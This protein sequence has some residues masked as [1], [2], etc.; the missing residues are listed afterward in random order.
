MDRFSELIISQSQV[1]SISQ[2][3]LTP[4][5]IGFAWRSAIWRKPL[6]LIQVGLMQLIGASLIFSIGMIPID[7]V[8]H[9]SNLDRS[10]QERTAQLIWVD[11]VLTILLLSGANWWMFARTRRLQ[12]LVKLVE[13]IE[14][15]NQ[16][17]TS[18]STLAKVANLTA[19]DSSPNHHSQIFDILAQTR[20]NLLT[21]LEIDRYL[22]RQHSNSAGLTS[23]AHNLIDLQHLAQQP[24]LAD[25]HNLL[26]QAWEIGIGVYQETNLNSTIFGKGNS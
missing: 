2:Q 20:H 17:V 25:Y 21:G 7:R 22:R 18:I 15:Y 6:Q 4:L 13:R 10:P 3:E 23:L 9:R 26:T 11:G 12:H 8:L 1:E 24:E 5:T 16:I 14:D 19:I